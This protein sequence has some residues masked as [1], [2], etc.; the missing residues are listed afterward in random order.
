MAPRGVQARQM[1]DD[2]ALG[3]VCAQNC[4]ERSERES[5]MCPRTL[6]ELLLTIKIPIF[7]MGKYTILMFYVKSR[8]GAPGKP[9]YPLRRSDGLWRGFWRVHD[10]AS[11]A[12]SGA[13]N[14]KKKRRERPQSLRSAQELPRSRQGVAE[15]ALH[16]GVA[17]SAAQRTIFGRFGWILH[18][19]VDIF[20]GFLFVP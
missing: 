15:E 9:K 8:F 3:H 6:Q 5:T 17:T 16:G 1:R 20:L 2:G 13:Q 19:C 18:A 4:R 7:T 14:A 12:P 11:T 10:G